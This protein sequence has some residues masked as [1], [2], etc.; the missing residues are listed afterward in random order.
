MRLT[1]EDD[2]NFE[3]LSEHLFGGDVPQRT[4]SVDSMNDGRWPHEKHETARL[5]SLRLQVERKLAQRDRLAFLRQSSYTYSFIKSHVS[6]RTVH[7][8][9]QYDIKV[10]MAVA[11][12]CLV[13]GQST[14]G[15]GL[16]CG[17]FAVRPLYL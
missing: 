6:N 8:K 13:A 9:I 7:N 10:N 17:L 5:T 3:L 4:G 11:Y 2:D 12:C 15:A 1:F 14:V 16:A